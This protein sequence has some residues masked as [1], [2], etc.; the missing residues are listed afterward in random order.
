[1]IIKTLINMKKYFSILAAMV[2]FTSCADLFGPDD[3]FPENYY[4][5]WNNESCKA[6]LSEH[7]I[8]RP[9]DSASTMTWNLAGITEKGE[10]EWVQGPE[11]KHV[12]SSYEFTMPVTTGS[13]QGNA[14]LTIKPDV[15]IVT[16]SNKRYDLMY[17]S[18]TSV[19]DEKASIDSKFYDIP[20]KDGQPMGW[21]FGAG[22]TPQGIISR[23][24]AELSKVYNKPLLL[25]FNFTNVPAGT[26]I[27]IKDITIREYRYWGEWE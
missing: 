27:R 14:C 18:W 11:V 25:Q 22:F 1:M 5:E 13:K 10:Y 7:N 12:G 19:F 2:L 3:N 8:W 4:V 9:A 20:P 16:D 24:G 26:I 15:D 17:T 21:D 23:G 6:Y